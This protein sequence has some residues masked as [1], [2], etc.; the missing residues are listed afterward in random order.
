MR[1]LVTLGPPAIF[2][3]LSLVHPRPR[4]SSIAAALA[5]Q[6]GLWI[7][8]HLAQLV[9]V[10]LL[11]FAVWLLLEELPGVAAAVSRCALGFFVCFY[12]AFDA[13]VGLGT[14]LLVR[15]TAALS[16]ADAQVA[17]Q[18]IQG[19][20]DGRLDF[21]GPVLWVILAADVAWVIALFAAAAAHRRAGSPRVAV[22]LLAVS[23]LAFSIDHTWPSG[24]I[25]MAALLGAAALLTG[26]PDPA[27]RR[28]RR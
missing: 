7:A 26:R 20:W 19:F 22:L 16:G 12:A 1:R 23:G 24:T 3:L 25:G 21:R 18:V 6:V 14:G 2:A 5:P 13:L 17:Q 4:S 28:P 27:S 15:Q 11:G 10:A 9:L 8:V